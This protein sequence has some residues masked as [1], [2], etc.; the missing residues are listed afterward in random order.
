M[1][2]TYSFPLHPKLT[3]NILTYSKLMQEK[4]QQQTTFMHFLHLD[5]VYTLYTFDKE[6]TETKT[7]HVV[8]IPF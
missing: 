2:M 6:T 5:T 7:L 3:F 1:T 4:V 8:H